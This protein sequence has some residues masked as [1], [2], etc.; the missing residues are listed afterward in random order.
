MAASGKMWAFR[1]PGGPTRVVKSQVDLS[2]P[3]AKEIYAG[4]FSHNAAL[5]LRGP[6]KDKDWPLCKLI[7]DTEFQKDFS[8]LANVSDLTGL[9]RGVIE[10]DAKGK[11]VPR[12]WAQEKKLKGL[13]ARQM[14]AKRA[15]KKETVP[16]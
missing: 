2:E 9:M 14:A 12:V 15:V 6:D 4:S 10:V 11:M 13:V 7:D 16:A 1:M 5:C 8:Q 3:K